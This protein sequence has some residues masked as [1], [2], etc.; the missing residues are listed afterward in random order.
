MAASGEAAV[1]EGVPFYVDVVT[2]IIKRED[3]FV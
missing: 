1:A 2:F 3:F